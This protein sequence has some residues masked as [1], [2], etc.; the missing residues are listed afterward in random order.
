MT[1]MYGRDDEKM[2]VSNFSDVENVMR[3]LFVQGAFF[4]EQNVPNLELRSCVSAMYMAAHTQDSEDI[5][6]VV[7]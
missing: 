6:R 2:S 7:D 4:G 5:P 1:E 3:E